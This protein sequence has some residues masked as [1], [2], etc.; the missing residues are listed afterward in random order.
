MYAEKTKC[1]WIWALKFLV[2]HSM[3]E[4]D[5]GDTETPVMS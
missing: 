5:R 1:Q 2:I 4:D 3:N